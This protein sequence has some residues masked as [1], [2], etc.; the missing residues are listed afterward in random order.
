MAKIGLSG[1]CHE[2]ATTKSSLS[3]YFSPVNRTFAGR[4]NISAMTPDPN[5][6]PDP[7]AESRKK[8]HIDLAFQSR[9][10]VGELDD[11]FNYEP[12][13]AAHPEPGSLPPLPFL[14]KTLRTPV[15]VSSM[16]GGT[17]F[18][19]TINRNL[20]RACGEFGMGMGLG[21]CRQ[22]LYS[23]EHLPDFDVR[24]LMGP[25]LPLYANLGVAQIEQLLDNVEASRISGLLH[26]LRADGLIVH[27]N[28]LQEAM[29]PEGDRFRYPPLETLRR[30]LKIADY[31]VIVKEV[32]QGIGPA[33]MSELMQLPLAAVEFA[34]AGGTNFAKLELQ[35]SGAEKRQIFEKM[36]RVGHSAV[37]MVN[38]S[39]FLIGSLGKRRNVDAVI[40]SG[41]IQDFLDGYFLIKKSNMP[42]V[43]GQASVFLQYARGEYEELRAYIQSQVRGLELASAFLRIKEVRYNG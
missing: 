14:G 40:I 34:A 32:G 28:P 15:W 23:D 16:T 33:S 11:R 26:R 27:V 31:P 7:T 41:G 24:D 6:L 1:F 18:A 13:L 39:N 36:A 8:D 3:C 17:E 19:R 5:Q 42:A 20:A 4:S 25:D 10:A 43:Y 30:L 2:P 12:M 21:S 22:L 38:R 35:R 37:E 29:Q 9:V